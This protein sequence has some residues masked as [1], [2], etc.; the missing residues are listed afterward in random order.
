MKTVLLG[1][2]GLVA[3]YRFGHGRRSLR[4]SLTKRRLLSLRPAM[5]GPVSISAPMAAGESQPLYQPSK[6]GWRKH[7]I[8]A[9]PRSIAEES[10]GGQ[11]GY[12]WQAGQFVF[13]LKVRA[14]GRTSADPGSA[15]TFRRSQP[16]SRS[17]PWA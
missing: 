4:R 7:C 3:L 12:R 2:I 1:T 6:R 8:T 9:A 17:T 14:T 10:F 16:A 11:L 13:G 5:T 15:P